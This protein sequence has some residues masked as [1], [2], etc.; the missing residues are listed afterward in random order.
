MH[1]KTLVLASMSLSL[2]LGA[3]SKEE[4]TGGTA[5]LLGKIY[6]KDYNSNGQ[7]K[8]EYYAP[9]EDVYIIY[10]NNTIFG[11]DTKTNYDGAYQF[12]ELRTGNY[13]IFAYSDCDSCASGVMPVFQSV[14]IEIKGKE[15]EVPTI[16]IIK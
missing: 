14:E 10:G 7:L 15:V 2:G 6:V 9:A 11:D 12:D 16:T 1:Y 3:C 5:T 4:G 8:G 13:T